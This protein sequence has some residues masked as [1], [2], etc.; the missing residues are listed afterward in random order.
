MNNSHHGHNHAMHHGE[1]SS[2]DHH[3]LMIQ[4]FKKRFVVSTIMS[5]PLIV[6]PFIHFDGDVFIWLALSTFV[7]FYGGKPFFVHAWSEMLRRQ[8]GMMVLIA[9][10]ISVSYGYSVAV[11]FGLPGM[12][13]FGELC[14]LI[15]IMLLGHWLEMRSV[16]GASKALA[17]LAQLL[18]SRAHVLV[19]ETAMKEF[20]ITELQEGMHI[21]VLPGEK[22]PADGVIIK[23]QS[24]V[25]QALI[26]GESIPVFKKIDDTVLAGSINGDGPLTL[27]IERVKNNTYIARIIDLVQ[28]VLASKSPMQDL[29]DKAAVVLTFVALFGGLTT[30]FVW[31]KLGSLSVALERMVTLMVTACPHALGLAIPLVIVRLTTLAAQNGLLIRNRTAFE[32]MRSVQT[33]IFDKTGTLT[34]GKLELTTLIPVGQGTEND[35]LATAASIEAYAQHAMAKALVQEAHN[36]KLPLYEVTRAMTVPGKGASGIVRGEEFFVGNEL[37]MKEK[38]FAITH[39]FEQQVIKL[40]TSGSLVIYLADKHGIKAIIA[41]SDRV[42]KEAYEVCDRLKKMHITVGMIT[43]D[44]KNTAQAIAA[45]LGVETVLADVLPHEKAAEIEKL[46]QAGHIVAMVGDGINDAP[47][48]A[49][50]DIGIAIG[51]G[52]DVAIETADI[53]LIRSNLRAVL[54]AVALSRLSWRKMLE[55]VFWATGYNV[56]ALPLAAGALYAYGVSFSPAIGAFVMS[57][58][59]IVVALNARFISYKKIDA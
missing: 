25:D 13:F 49:A 6:A 57:M 50:A 43:G 56:I 41:A 52:T 29:A 21:V 34:E 8:P 31:L 10:A 17:T 42:R 26:T 12:M 18:P 22:I 39:D 16:A 4:D 7:F 48:L 51:A 58:S 32:K 19:N 59:T 44:N 11:V 14:T 54:D 2:A 27:R 55:N 1:A 35:L 15:D 30:F 5:L 46:R 3:L 47:A 36:R 38:G 33:I 9:L 24:A 20:S 23:G 53:V 40:T 37:Y 45:Q 28:R